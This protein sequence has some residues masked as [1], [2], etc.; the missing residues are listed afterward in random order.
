M[1]LRSNMD[2]TNKDQ[3]EYYRMAHYNQMDKCTRT[4]PSQYENKFHHSSKAS[5]RKYQSLFEKID[6]KIVSSKKFNG[7]S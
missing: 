3:F 6:N 5:I 4:C 7:Y 2:M 1:K